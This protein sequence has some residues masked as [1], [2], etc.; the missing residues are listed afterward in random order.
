[1]KNQHLPCVT[2]LGSD[3]GR[4]NRRPVD[5]LLAAK[6]DAKQAKAAAAK[7]RKAARLAAAE[8]DAS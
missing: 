8:A 6:W 7:A 5:P 3:A 1:M 2:H 4:R